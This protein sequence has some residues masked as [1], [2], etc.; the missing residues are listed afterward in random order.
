MK[1][2]INDLGYI[3]FSVG[4][5]NAPYMNRDID[6]KLSGNSFLGICDFFLRYGYYLVKSPWRY[7]KKIKRNDA[8][9]VY[10]E[11]T[12]NRNTLQPIIKELG[13]DKVIDINSHILYPK[14]KQ[15]WYALPH[16]GS[17]IKEINRSDADK[18]SI[19]RYFFAKFWHM[20][21]CNKAAGE[22]LDFYKPRAVV[23]ANDHLHFHRALMHEANNRGIPTIYVQHASVT[24]K[25]PPLEFAYSLLDGEDSYNKYKLK[26][27]TS[28]K[29]YLTGGIRFD[30]IKRT[31]QNLSGKTV[32]GVAINQIDDDSIIKETC[33][34]LYSL[35]DSTN[36]IE[37]I[38]RPHP[39]M[40][41]EMWREWCKQNNIGFSV[42]R[43]ETSFDF[44]SRVSVLVSNQ[45][46]IHLDAAMCH[47]PTVVYNLSTSEVDDSY[48]FVRNGL[49]KEAQNINELTHFILG[50]D[51]KQ[52]SEKAVKY[53]NCSYGSSYEGHVARMMADLIE[54]I[55]DNEKYFNEK[56]HFEKV[57]DDNK[58]IVFRSV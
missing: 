47:T 12:N 55:P 41:L 40:Q 27:E 6:N 10:G 35:N 38:L 13:Q 37:V 46:S 50:K 32:V 24:E 36:I 16:L 17:L 31:K 19:I 11:S 54:S 1:T 48:S 28:G 42:A 3:Y 49:A 25:F 44:L 34:K 45:C 9:L 33:I 21:G 15:Y 58:K 43:E 53:Y 20:Y 26:E 4:K 2:D 22:L 5:E 56:Y 18:K 39:Q 30:G 29:I 51:Y 14:W 23:L 57:E 7:N 52:V 8:V